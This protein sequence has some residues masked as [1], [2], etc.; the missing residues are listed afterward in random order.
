[1]D[2]LLLLFGDDVCLEIRFIELLDVERIVGMSVERWSTG[3]CR[4]LDGVVLRLQLMGCRGSPVEHNEHPK[5]WNTRF[6]KSFVQRNSR[7][8]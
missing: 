2:S 6:E 1:M 3:L 7:E 5:S 8:V 4:R